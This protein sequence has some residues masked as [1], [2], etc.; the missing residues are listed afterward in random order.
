MDRKLGAMRLRRPRGK[1]TTAMAGGCAVLVVIAVVLA[2]GWQLHSRRH[3]HHHGHQRHTTVTDLDSLPAK[4]T[5]NGHR[6][7][8][9]FVG[10]GAISGGSANSRLLIDYYETHHAAQAQQILDYLFKPHFGAS[11][12]ILKLEIGG[13]ANAT[14]GAEPSYQHV[15]GSVNCG[16]GYEFW[17]AQQAL[18]L[19]PALKIYAL[20]WNAPH[21]VGEGQQNAWTQADIA[22]VIGWLKCARADK[23]NVSYIGGWNEH[24]PKGVTPQVI[25]WFI[26][27]RSALD[28][29]GFSS[30]QIVAVDSFPHVHGADVADFLADH[31]LFDK[32]VGVIGYH[33][34]CGHMSM[35]G[36]CRVPYAARVSGKPI[37]EAELGALQPPAGFG[38]IAR[39]INDSYIQAGV[40]G[41]IEWPLL[42]SMPADLPVEN[43]G[44]VQASQPWSGNYSVSQ[45]TWVIAQTT[46]FTGPGWRHVRDA[47]GMLPAGGSYVSYESP[48][49]NQWSLVAQTSDAVESQGIWVHIT[50]GLPSTIVHVWRTKLGPA[51]PSQIFAHVG[52]VS[53][54]GGAFKYTL[55]PGYVYSFTTTTGQSKGTAPAPPRATPMPLP[56]TATPDAVNVAYVG[57][58][59]V[60]EPWGLCAIDGAFEYPPGDQTTF[61][62]TAVGTPD[63]WQPPKPGQP[64][65]FP[66]AVVGGGTWRNYTVSTQVQFAGKAQSAGVIA[67]YHRSSFT[68]PVQEFAGYEFTVA[69]SGK[70]RLLHDRLGRRAQTLAS[71]QVARL[72]TGTWH[73]ITLS[74]HGSKLV[75]L[76]DNKR[77]VSK[78]N[79]EWHSGVAGIMTGGWYRVVFRNLTVTT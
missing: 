50:G 4:I 44:L 31:K 48:A 70:W 33:D 43:L 56:Y 55:S 57:Q 23:I 73:T 8:P 49:Q 71:G 11:L 35:P 42:S 16:E 15:Q 60:S 7:G 39:S 77:V 72:G 58:P 37:F 78:S 75:G 25:N 69:A 9:V 21:W 51:S 79:S 59:W 41:T 47:S 64:P 13:D 74:V 61:A 40:T 46:Q 34:V 30:V 38:A 53:P 6:A 19:N 67:R 28:A 24:L 63:F 3:R 76:I 36:H 2:S 62:Q 65:R 54:S 52:D 17:L 22:N 20:Q 26:S 1:T 5:I 29:A 68:T 14:D 27:L 32:A 45:I 18:E 66:F 10:V 12:Q